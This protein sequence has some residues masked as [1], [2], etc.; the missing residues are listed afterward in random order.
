MANFKG[1][2]DWET[3]KKLERI[4]PRKHKRHSS[5]EL[6]KY[7]CTEDDEKLHITIASEH[8]TQKR[9]TE[10]LRNYYSA[11]KIRL[12]NL[13]KRVDSRANSC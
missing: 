8:R 10:L 5:V 3:G 4:T 2:E 13:R 9:H 7:R 1:P 11:S 12:K 6:R